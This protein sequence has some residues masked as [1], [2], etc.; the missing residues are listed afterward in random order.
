[1]RLRDL[2]EQLRA[3]HQ[4]GATDPSPHTYH[5]DPVTFAEPAPVVLPPE[6]VP[7]LSSKPEAGTEAVLWLRDKLATPKRIG[8][9][10][11]AWAGARDGDTG[12]WIGDLMAARWALSVQVYEG[13]DGL[14][15]WRLRH[16]TVQ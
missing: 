8:A 10:V 12:R 6:A 14:M 15:W 7:P 1:M 16:P 9:L 13:V 2:Q 11:A 4:A 3:K 5:Q